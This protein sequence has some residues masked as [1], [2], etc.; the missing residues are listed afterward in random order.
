MYLTGS[1]A[2][3]LESAIPADRRHGCGPSRLRGFTQKQNATGSLAPIA[4]KGLVE[5]TPHYYCDRSPTPWPAS[6][7]HE[8]ADGLTR[9]DLPSGLPKLRLDFG[10]DSG[11]FL[12]FRDG[13]CV[14]H[15]FIAEV[16]Q[17]FV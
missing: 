1:P 8:A 16:L 9:G 5:A 15:E 17:V 12:N 10:N 13:R 6:G 3:W 2:P 7:A 11:G 4:E 14:H